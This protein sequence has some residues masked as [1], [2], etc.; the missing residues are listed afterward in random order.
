MKGNKIRDY[1][2]VHTITKLMLLFLF[3]L[4]ISISLTY[5][6]VSRVFINR[7]SI[8]DVLQ[9]S[10]LFNEIHGDEVVFQ[11]REGNI[12]LKGLFF[13]AKIQS[14]KT[15]I[16]VHGYNEN[17]LMSGRTKKIVEYLT[18]RRYNVLTFDLR[19]HGHSEGDLISFGYNEKFDVIGAIDYLSKRGKEGEKIALLGFSMGA[20]AAIEAAGQDPR[21]DVII[22]DSPIRDLKLFIS[23]DLKNLSDNLDRILTDLDAKQYYTILKYLPFKGKAIALI[24]KFYGIEIDQVSPLNTVK[25]SIKQPLLLI[26]GKYD[27]YISYTN[28][29]EI[30]KLAKNNCKT[31]IWITQNADHVQSLNLYT[32]EYLEKLE[33]FLGQHM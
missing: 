24:C 33:K 12:T 4:L 5:Y 30:Y 20:V 16:L 19:G 9:V 7:V 3:I 8:D 11:S 21:I 10:W 13:P 14:N 23:T 1:K 28:S 22:A 25:K 31:E 15:L 18:P 6:K 26:H 32:D 2:R 29:E 17:R 27:E